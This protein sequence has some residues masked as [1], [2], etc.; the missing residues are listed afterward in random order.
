MSLHAFY[1]STAVRTGPHNV[2]VSLLSRSI[3]SV[4]TSSNP[5][6]YVHTASNVTRVGDEVLDLPSVNTVLQYCCC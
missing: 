1:C 5:P 3:A 4:R 2:A 6:R